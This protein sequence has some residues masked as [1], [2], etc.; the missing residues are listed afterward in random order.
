M[1][2]ILFTYFMLFL[3]IIPNFS[4][5]QAVSVSGYVNNGSNGNALESVNIFEKNSGIG[6][7]TNQNG[8][9]KLVLKKGILNLTVTNDGFKAYSHMLELNSD[10][11]LI[12]NLQANIAEKSKQEKNDGLHADAKEEKKEMS[13]RGFKLF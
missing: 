2:T 11:T 7:I 3:F 10:T 9:Y 5:A 4:W 6:T 1:K 12:V 13:R 8:F